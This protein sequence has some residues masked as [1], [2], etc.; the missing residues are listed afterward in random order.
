MF[1]F[2]SVVRKMCQMMAYDRQ[3]EA[4][5]NL[6]FSINFFNSSSSILH[7]VLIVFSK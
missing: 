1:A 2:L 7:T 4:K 3:Y 6:E 5:K